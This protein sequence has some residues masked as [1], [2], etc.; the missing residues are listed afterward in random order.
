MTD[1]L[2][3]SAESLKDS[4]ADLVGVIRENI[5]LT[6]AQV[7]LASG[8]PASWV[9]GWS[10]SCCSLFVVPLP[11]LVHR[12]EDPIGA[13]DDELFFFSRKTLVREVLPC[14][15]P[16]RPCFRRP[17]GLSLLGRT[18]AL[19]SPPR[20][21]AQPPVGAGLVGNSP[22]FVAAQ[23]VPR[24]IDGRAPRAL[25]HDAK[26]CVSTKDSDVEGLSGRR[27]RR[28]SLLP[29]FPPSR[30]HTVLVLPCVGFAKVVSAE[31]AGGVVAGYV[32][33]PVA[34]G[35]G[36][37][38][39]LVV[40]RSGAWVRAGSRGRE[41]SRSC[42]KQSWKAFWLAAASAVGTAPKECTSIPFTHVLPSSWSGAHCS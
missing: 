38:A 17:R 13:N 31:G 42:G 29:R 9:M 16:M 5:L 7:V 35:M 8:S 10:E 34:P 1:S 32:H 40:L 36:K 25:A 4:L 24:S 11:L 39:S 22:S 14:L 26:A 33:A 15:V 3:G 20:A 27:R 28:A 21:F 2:Q 37:N 12:V 6:R 18:V 19:S 41:A 23:P 30:R